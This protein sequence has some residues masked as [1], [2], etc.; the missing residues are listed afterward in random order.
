MKP[1]KLRILITGCTNQHIGKPHALNYALTPELVAQA[2][3]AGHEVDQRPVV[4]GEK[5]CRRYDQAIVFYYNPEARNSNWIFG[6]L[7]TL[8]ELRQS[9]I[10]ID[11]ATLGRIFSNT[12]RV[13]RDPSLLTK[14]F[15]SPKYVEEARPY[16]DDF[17]RTLADLTEGRGHRLAL[18]IFPWCD[19]SKMKM[20]PRTDRVRWYD[21]SPLV[22]P[23]YHKLV[24]R[25]D[26]LREQ[27]WIFG[28]CL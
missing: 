16:L 15:L 27:R 1:T 23:L 19:P 26:K 13:V 7:W 20:V 6:A 22:T 5:L 18:P 9:V 17:V 24:R 12:R 2:L 4:P 11:D 14:P 28:A 10:A 3:R 8:R 21:P 25:S